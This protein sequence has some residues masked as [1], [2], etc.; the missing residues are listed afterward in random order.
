MLSGVASANW[1]GAI[2]G[3]WTQARAESYPELADGMP[4]VLNKEYTQFR[5]KIKKGIYWSD[6][7]EF[8]AD[9][10]IYTL[11][12]TSR[13]KAKITNGGAKTVSNYVKSFKKVDNYTFEVET[14]GPKYDLHHGLGHLYL[15]ANLTIRAQARLRKAGRCH[16][17]SATPIRSRLGPYTL[18]QFD[19]QRLL[20][21][22]ATA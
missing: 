12:T 11:D 7:V 18:K 14:A 4:E 8:T 15:G 9:D 5:I 19:P 6:G 2:C 16:R 17:P 3:K 21:V 10:I 13:T 22:L 20:G 1:A